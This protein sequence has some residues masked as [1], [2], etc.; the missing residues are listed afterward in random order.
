MTQHTLVCRL[1]ESCA[2]CDSQHF[3]RHTF[4]PDLETLCDFRAVRFGLLA[5]K[6]DMI[7]VSSLFSLSGLTWF[8]CRNSVMELG[9]NI[10]RNVITLIPV[11]SNH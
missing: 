1:V 8:F 6:G 9:E 10:S 7:P 2:P 3:P 11:V 5:D 4:L